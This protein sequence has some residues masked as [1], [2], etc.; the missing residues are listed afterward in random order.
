MYEVIFYKGLVSRSNPFT[1]IKR[2]HRPLSDKLSQNVVY[3]EAT[4]ATFKLKL[5]KVICSPPKKKFYISGN[6][7]FLSPK[8]LIRLFLNFCM[9]RVYVRNFFIIKSVIYHY[10]ILF[11]FS[12]ILHYRQV[13]FQIRF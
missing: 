1:S 13:R 9:T 6:G 8:N 11:W 5:K 3:Y 4:W 10:E 7:T 12:K 2:R